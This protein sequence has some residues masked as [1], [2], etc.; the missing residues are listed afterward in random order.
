MVFSEV[1]A[2]AAKFGVG[3]SSGWD[4][5]VGIIGWSLGGG[6]GPF[7]PKMGLG[8][9]NIVNA[10]IVT[11]RGD[12]IQVNASSNEDLF[13]AIRGGGGS[14]WG[15]F[16]SIDVQTHPI[17]TS[18]YTTVTL[19]WSDKMCGEGYLRFEKVLQRYLEWTQVRDTRWAGTTN[20]ES[21][22]KLVSHCPS[23]W[24]V[25]MAYVYQGSPT[26][27]AFVDGI[28]E[29]IQSVPT[30]TPP[31]IASCV[32]WWDCI[33]VL[34]PSSFVPLPYLAPSSHYV[35]AIP[36]VLVNRTTW[37]SHGFQ[38][39]SELVVRC[40]RSDHNCGVQ[41]VCQDLT[42]NIGSPQDTTTSINAGLRKGIVHV[43][44]GGENFSLTEVD[45]LFY[46][47]GEYSYF[48][49]SAYLMNG[50][51]SR[52]WGGNAENLRKIKNT[53]D[54]EGVFGCHHCVGEN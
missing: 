39:I 11:P 4:A 53:Y 24:K 17:S 12:L 47:F 20:F 25:A 21:I 2:A 49:E 9:D 51:E 3:V 54:P 48:S 32:T 23:S 16:T 37:A 50:W 36:S 15:V 31:E 33:K 10:E 29:I 38:M 52:Y 6:H 22:P 43:I 8:V 26:D 1:H 45:Q 27:K 18:G 35:G 46:R 34:P 41:Q 40:N 42:G 7:A 14:T 28:H 5:T 19:K 30:D 44:G 13:W